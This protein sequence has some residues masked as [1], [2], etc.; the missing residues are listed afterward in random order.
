MAN[1]LGDMI[2][3]RAAERPDAP[4]IT[5]QDRTITYGELDARS[6]RV[7]QALRA[8]GIERG[9]RVAILDKNVPEFFELL[10]GAVKLGAVLAAV[11]WR[12]APP[13]IAAV[14]NDSTARVLLVGAEFLPCVE[15]IEPK[16]ETVELVVTTESGTSRPGFA[17][18]ATRN[19]P[20]ISTSTS[21]PTRSRC[22]STRRARP[23]FPRV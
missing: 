19:R 16:L 1:T 6:N 2:R 20:T 13:E 12:L 18:G 3:E 14:L 10:L 22:S 15:E 4:A 21:R 5:Y 17:D 7:A 8:A 9:D 11:N 23:V